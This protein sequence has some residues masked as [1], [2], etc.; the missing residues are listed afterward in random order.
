M[1]GQKIDELAR[2]V[3]LTANRVRQHDSQIYQLQTTLLIVED[4]LKLIELKLVFGNRMDTLPLS[5]HR[6][7]SHMH[8]KFSI[9]GYVCHGHFLVDCG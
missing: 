2:Y 3:D 6:N 9:K 5:M 7:V 1:Q 4:G 8:A